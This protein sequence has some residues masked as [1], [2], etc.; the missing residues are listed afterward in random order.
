MDHV[1]GERLTKKVNEF[2]IERRGGNSMH[3]T[4][5]QDGVKKVCNAR[6]LVLKEAE[7]FCEW[8]ERSR[9]NSRT[10]QMMILL[11]KL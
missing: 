10:L 4:R 3:C 6:S 5:W 1:F 2:E 8:V 7:V 11:N 9:G